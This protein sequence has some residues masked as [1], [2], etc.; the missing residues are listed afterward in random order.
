MR[1]CIILHNMIVENERD[2]YSRY[3]AEEF[4]EGDVTRSSEV[5]TKR[6]TN[7]NNLFPNRNDLRDRHMHERLKND[8]IK[9]I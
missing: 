4:E 7:M 6:P 2:G 1:A 3:D 8:L 5:E 9:N